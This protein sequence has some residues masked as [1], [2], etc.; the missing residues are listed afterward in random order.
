M[1]GYT[2]DSRLGSLEADV[3]RLIVSVDTIHNTVIQTARGSVL[4]DTIA[5][6]LSTISTRLQ[7]VEEKLRTQDNAVLV[8]TG[9]R[10][11]RN[12]LIRIGLSVGLTGLMLWTGKAWQ[13]IQQLIEFA[14]RNIK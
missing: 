11:W 7:S 4:L 10:T 9:I 6:E 5:K 12:N 8:Q 3:R 13:G 2:T 14:L 1:N